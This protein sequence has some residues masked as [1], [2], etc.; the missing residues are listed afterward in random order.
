MRH[1]PNKTSL[2]AIKQLALQESQ[3]RKLIQSEERQKELG[4]VFTPTELVIQ[5]LTKLPTGLQGVWQEDK[6]FLDPTCGNGQF[7]A[8]ILI[9][10]IQLGHKDPLS[11]IFGVDIMEDNVIACRERLL[12]IAGHSKKNIKWVERNIVCADGLTYDY[13]FGQHDLEK[14]QAE[15]A[16]WFEQLEKD[17]E[18]WFKAN[19]PAK[20]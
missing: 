7:L 14:R 13:D 2:K 10:K 6:T 19:V 3:G 20:T 17:Q 5:M 4:E 1:K 12:E 9:I 15:E 16:A 18:K 8:A 11:T